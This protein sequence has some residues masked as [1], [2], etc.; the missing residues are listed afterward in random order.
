M[1]FA[2]LY[3]IANIAAA[4]AKNHLKFTISKMKIGA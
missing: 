1:L 2:R 3:C 4:P